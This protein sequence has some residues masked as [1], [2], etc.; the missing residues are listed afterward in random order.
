MPTLLGPSPWLLQHGLEELEHLI[1]AILF[2]PAAVIIITD[3]DGRSTDIS[4]G[5]A[6]LLDAPRE[7]LIGQLMQ[8]LLP[9]AE[10][11]LEVLSRGL[12]DH[13]VHCGT[14]QFQGA[15]GKPMTMESSARA[16]L[17]PGRHAVALRPVAAALASGDA[18]ERAQASVQ[19]L[20]LMLLSKDG[21]ILAWYAGAERIYGWPAAEVIGRK[22]SFLWSEGRPAAEGIPAEYQRAVDHFHRASE[23]WHLRKDGSRMWVNA[24]TVAL[25][26]ESGELQGFAR[27]T[28]DFTA[29]HGRE[30]KLKQHR[31]AISP[32]PD[33]STVVGVVSGEYDRITEAN[34][35]FLEMMGYEQHA[36]ASGQ[37]RWPDLTPPEYEPLDEIAYE[38]ALRFGA[39]S[40]YEKD[41]LRH[42]GARVPVL[43]ITSV[44]ALQPLR[45]ISMV[46]DLSTLES[47]EAI[48]ASDALLSSVFT[49]F[50]GSSAAVR[51][52]QR[53]MTV[54]APTDANVLVLGETGTGKELIARAVH[55]LSPRRNMPFISLNCAAIPTGLLESE[56]F[57]YERGAFTG[58]LSQKMGRFEL[59]HR[60]T[61]FLDEV[62]DIPLELQ[63]KL[64]RALQEKSFERLGGTKTIPIDVRLVAATNRNLEEMMGANLFR[65][66]LYYRLRV[67]PITSPPLRDRP[68]D[69]PE[70]VRH[71]TRKYSERMNRTVD[72][73]PPATML[74]L[75]SWSWPGNIRELENFI[76][77]AVILS[78]GSTLRAPL[79]EIRPEPGQVSGSSTLIQVERDHIVRVL[80]EC[81][82]VVST[83][84][85]RLGMYRTT[86]NATMR[87]LGIS[88]KD[89]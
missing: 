34:D 79:E 53:L 45:W 85:A 25:R 68:E 11:G 42:D 69:I 55:R 81:N 70:L 57:G 65:S 62:G 31:T 10:L 27:A 18:K 82:G 36:I 67:F 14:L 77:R 4:V 60:G 87:K 30:E 5:A 37:L 66:D 63:P 83:A 20:A 1:P 61:L 50:I 22:E 15:G 52:V 29:R 23:A 17:L 84:A 71:F 59:A 78:D 48:E 2:R 33:R 12:D 43:M 8:D 47:D 26:D 51:R 9:G 46:Q 32:P 24:I 7:T 56:L 74:A 21:V 40:P 54:V 41:L 6:K 73:I 16:N 76:E 44:T 38:E 86:L 39:C 75:V 89:F 72:K 88:R 80:R 13:G 64:L 49:E 35:R 28:R 3:A 19:D 58:A